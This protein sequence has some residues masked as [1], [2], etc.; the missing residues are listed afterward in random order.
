MIEH[1]AE[2]IELLLWALGGFA[3]ALIALG[4]ILIKIGKWIAHQVSQRLIGIES[5]IKEANQKLEVAIK[6]TN[7]TLG[8]VTG[9]LRDEL[10]KLERRHEDRIVEV[11]RRVSD[12]STHCRVYHKHDKD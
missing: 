5:A 9:A 8:Q 12:I 2:V 10:L 1:A 4:G 6:E 11:E 7:T 3:A